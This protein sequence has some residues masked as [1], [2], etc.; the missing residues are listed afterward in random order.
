MRLVFVRS[1]PWRCSIH[2]LRLAWPSRIDRHHP[3]WVS[4]IDSTYCQDLSPH[5]VLGRATQRERE[6]M[7]TDGVRPFC[8][9]LRILAW[10]IFCPCFD[11]VFQEFYP[12]RTS[13][14]EYPSAA[15]WHRPLRSRSSPKKRIDCDERCRKCLAC[16]LVEF[17]LHFG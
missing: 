1:T 11:R 2:R 17:L 15:A 16:Y 12:V 6:T 3:L 14:V 8:L 10:T 13:E 7:Y 4:P 5:V 9:R